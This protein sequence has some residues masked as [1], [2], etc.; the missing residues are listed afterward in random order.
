MDAWGVFDYGRMAHRMTRKPCDGARVMDSSSGGIRLIPAL[1]DHLELVGNLPFFSAS[2]T[3]RQSAPSAG[4]GVGSISVVS[5]G[6]VG[7]TLGACTERDRLFR[8]GKEAKEAASTA[9]CVY[10]A[11]EK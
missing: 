1:F 3:S 11:S 2:S 8:V 4:S 6:I 7:V 9:G 5:S 10:L